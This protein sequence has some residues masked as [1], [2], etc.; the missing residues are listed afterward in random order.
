MITSYGLALAR[1]NNVTNQ[2][3]L[4][5]IKKR[6]TY[7]Y[8]TFVK[9]IYNKNN[10]NELIKLFNNMTIE[11]KLCI[12]SLNFNIIWF[13]SYLSLP[14]KLPLKDLTKYENCR[15]KFEKR[16]LF[17]DGKRLLKL[18]K[19]TKSAYG[20]WEMPKGMINKNESDINAAIR[21]FCEE[22]GIKKNKYKILYDKDPMVYTFVDDNTTY[23]YVYYL[24]VMLDKKYFPCIELSLEKNSAIME[25]MDIKFFNIHYISLI[26]AGNKN[27]INFAKNIIKIVK[28]YAI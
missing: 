19:N 27:F 22:T 11:E 26:Y 13:K 3:E 21:E 4:L 10:D 20:I 23:K 16:F 5:F 12:S 24:A 1:K 6:L 17:D 28:K 14:N 15:S 7:A 25:S 8:I 9:G 18:I 2:Y